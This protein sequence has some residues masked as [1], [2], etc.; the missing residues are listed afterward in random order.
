MSV[1]TKLF[2]AAKL[3]IVVGATLSLALLGSAASASVFW[4]E[5]DDA[6]DYVTKVGIQREMSKLNNE[7]GRH[8]QRQR[9]E[10]S[11]LVKS[12]QGAKEAEIVK[13][14]GAKVEEKPETSVLPFYEIGGRGFS[15]LFSLHPLTPSKS[16]QSFYQIGDFAG[17][18]VFYGQDGESV[19]TVIFY[20]RADETYPGLKGWNDLKSRIQWDDAHLAQLKRWIAQ[21][22]AT[23]TESPS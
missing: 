14:F 20:F 11:D 13:L 22:R 21:R 4:V 6:S 9:G 12:F 8:F 5:R 23:L 19:Q 3:K 16:H 10:L 1:N 18:K 15:G 17:A 7:T 2:R